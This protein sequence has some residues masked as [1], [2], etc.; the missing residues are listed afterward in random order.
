MRLVERIFHV[1]PSMDKKPYLL[2]FLSFWPSDYVVN[3]L[4]F[5]L[6]DNNSPPPCSS[7]SSSTNLPGLL[8]S[9]FS[10]PPV[11]SA[12]LYSQFFD[13]I[14]NKPACPP[15]L[16][17]LRL[18][19]QKLTILPLR[20]HSQQPACPLSSLIYVPASKQKW[21]GGLRRK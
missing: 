16:S 11:L 10:T 4:S 14:V 15:V 20:S 9:H 8:S 13:Y 19:S 7:I 2:V 5:F 17:I 6:F 21:E 18:H 12:L 1:S 3:R